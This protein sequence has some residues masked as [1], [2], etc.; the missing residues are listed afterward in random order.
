MASSFANWFRG[1]PFSSTPSGSTGDFGHAYRGDAGLPV[2]R[3]SVATTAT[4]SGGFESGGTAA[5]S[6]GRVALVGVGVSVG[7]SSYA[8]VGRSAA[9]SGGVRLGGAGGASVPEAA[10]DS[11]GYWRR[12]VSA[13]IASKRG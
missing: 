3:A 8:T 12:G 11:F 5:A 6:V 9:P 7:G 1:A 10:T 13:S 4:A 2:G